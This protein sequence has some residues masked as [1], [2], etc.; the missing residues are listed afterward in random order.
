MIKREFFV[1]N[2]T[3]STTD[4]S[5]DDCTKCLFF[6]LFVLFC[7]FIIYILLKFAT[8]NKLIL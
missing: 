5:V 3:G 4:I 1:K 8:Y 7:I 2:Q 6:T